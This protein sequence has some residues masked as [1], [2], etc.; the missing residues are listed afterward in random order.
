MRSMA[1]SSMSTD[2]P[3][4][5]TLLPSHR[6]PTPLPPGRHELYDRAV[7]RRPLG[8]VTTVETHDGVEEKGPETATKSIGTPPIKLAPLLSRFFRMALS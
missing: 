7:C 1:T 3:S 5:T 4:P 2:P 6:F 8:A